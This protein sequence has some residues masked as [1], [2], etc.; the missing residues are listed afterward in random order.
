MAQ[1][2]CGQCGE[3]FEPRRPDQSYCSKRCKE[4]ARG[5]RQREAAAQSSCSVQGCDRPTLAGLRAGLCSMHYRRK[6][7]TGDVGTP[8]R[9]RGGRM[10][11]APCSVAGCSRKY[12]AKDLCRLHYSR[13]RLTGD[14]GAV[15]TVKRANGEGSYVDEKGYRRIAYQS[16]GRVRKVFEHRL[17]MQRIL[18]RDLHSFETVHHKNGQRADNRPANLELWTKPQPA[19]QR[20]EDVVAWVVQ[21]YPDLVRA[22]L[23]AGT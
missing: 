7:L 22:A 13:R 10:N 12:Y 3:Q 2:T 6:R 19:G 9:T 14:V 11:V 18:G 23:E 4:R 5:R 8:G 21:Y 17:V 15:S 1:R 20:P 16:G